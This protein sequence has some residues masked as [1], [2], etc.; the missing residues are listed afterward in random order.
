MTAGHLQFSLLII[1]SIIAVF[2]IDTEQSQSI[3][4]NLG[5]A[6]DV[7]PCHLDIRSSVAGMPHHDGNL[8]QWYTLLREVRCKRTFAVIGRDEAKLLSSLLPA[9][10]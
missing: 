2:V 1:E 9:S 10:L 3:T 5:L 7:A 6:Y 4:I 8:L